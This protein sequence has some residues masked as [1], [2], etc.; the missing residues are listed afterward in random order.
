MVVAQ[1]KRPLTRPCPPPRFGASSSSDCSRP[2]TV[3]GIGAG[4]GRNLGPELQLRAVEHPLI[5]PPADADTVRRL[6]VNHHF[7]MR[8][9]DVGDLTVERQIHLG[10]IA[11]VIDEV[12]LARMTGELKAAA[13]EIHI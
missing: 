1:V 11:E 2:H 12:V 8:G 13:H 10:S 7:H 3:R 6:A 5:H 4:L 9:G